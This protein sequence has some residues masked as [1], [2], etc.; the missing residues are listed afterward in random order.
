[1]DN[2]CKELEDAQKELT[3]LKLEAKSLR[4]AVWDMLNYAQ[5]YVVILDRDMN[6]V[7]INY[8]LSTA[9]GFKNE[10][11]PIGRCW[12]DFIPPEGQDLVYVIHQKLAFEQDNSYRE[13]TNEILTMDGEKI[14]VKWFNIPI[15]SQ[16][17]MTFS[18]GLPRLD[19][20]LI[21]SEDAVRAY[22][23]DILHRDKT[24]IKSIRDSL[25]AQKRVESCMYKDVE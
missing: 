18:F 7:L 12:G 20:P 23:H 11:E 1:M 15:N 17:N 25:V 21:I 16:F 22:Y 6:I 14:L 2:I 10:K 9:L 24:M 13:V 4:K 5:M 8:S 19:T 3:E